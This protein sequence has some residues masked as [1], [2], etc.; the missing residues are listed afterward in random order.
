MKPNIV[1]ILVALV[2]V[3]GAGFLLIKG[4]RPTVIS[5]NETNEKLVKDLKTETVKAID[6]KRGDIAVKLEKNDKGWIL[7]SHKNRPAK[8]D[9]IASLLTNLKDA[10]KEGVRPSSNDALFDLDDKNRTEL[11][12][13]RDSGSTKLY[14]G[15]SPDAGKAFVKTEASNAIYEIDKGLDTDSGLRAEGKGRVLDPTYFYDLQVLNLNADDVIDITIKTDKSDKPTRV[16]KVLGE[17]KEPVQPKQELKPDDKP[18]WMLT[19]P[20]KAPADEGNINGIASNL[21]KLTAKGYA[22][23]V[24][25]RDRGLDKPVAVVTL[26]YKDGTEHT[27]TFGKVESDEVILVVE[28]KPDPFKVYK[29]HLE[30]VTKDLKKKDEEKKPDDAADPHQGIPGFPPAPGTPPVPNAPPKAEPLKKP[31]SAVP[32]IPSKVEPESKPVLP[33]AVVKPEEPAKKSDDKK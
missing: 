23:M 22:D 10:E 12:L 8:N 19:E 15:K 26:R 27:F 3:L 25:E 2:V 24:A 11:L 17:K 1:F 28:G 16:Q 32:A 33:P 9:R 18:T 14:I 6:I 29:Y 7:A 4:D 5:A 31:V 13:T 21:S 30:N 20:E